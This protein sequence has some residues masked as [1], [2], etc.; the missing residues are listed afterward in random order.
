MASDRKSR[1]FRGDWLAYQV[2]EADRVEVWVERYPAPG[3]RR[4]V[5]GEAGG[6]N[7]LWSPNGRELYYVRP[8]RAMMAVPI[9]TTPDLNVG[10]PE[11]LFMTDGYLVGPAATT[12]WD[13]APDGRFLMIKG[14]APWGTARLDIIHVQNWFQEL[15]RLAPQP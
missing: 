4:L 3:D 8:D 12:F 14:T 7:P 15:R 5:S 9:E 1:E 11:F 2:A 6:G 13:V 10:S